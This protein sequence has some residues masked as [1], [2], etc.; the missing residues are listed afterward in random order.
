MLG[1]LLSNAGYTVIATPFAV[2][3]Q[4]AI[5]T[6]QVHEVRLYTRMHVYKACTPATTCFQAFFD[7]LAAVRA[8]GLQWLAPDGLPTVG[9]GHSNGAL[10]QLLMGA[11]QEPLH[12]AAVIISYNNR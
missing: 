8:D 6:Q 3:F 4:H 9:V 5:C 11:M 1:H 7:T 2:T 10:L 12:D